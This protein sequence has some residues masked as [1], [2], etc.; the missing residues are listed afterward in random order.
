MSFINLMEVIYPIGSIHFSVDA[1]S[2]ASI[3]GG[4][5]SSIADRFLLGA[6]T[7]YKVNSTGG[8]SAHTLT[9]NEIPSHSHTGTNGTN[10]NIEVSKGGNTGSYGTTAGI[11]LEFNSNPYNGGGRLT[12]TCRH[13]SQYIYGEEQ[14]KVGEHLWQ[15]LISQI[16][17]EINS[18]GLEPTIFHQPL[19]AQLRYGVEV[20]HRLP[21]ADLLSQQEQVMQL[22]QQEELLQS[23][24][25]MIKSQDHYGQQQQEIVLEKL[26][27]YLAKE[28]TMGLMQS[29]EQLAT[30]MKTDLLILQHIFGEELAN[31]SFLGGVL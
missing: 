17:L 3:I 24:L 6:G 9:I 15:Q 8:E 31:T 26:K 4:T 12:T 13:T 16:G 25:D 11:N 18:I 2:P 14:P 20:G 22:E 1:A 23:L 5:W 27:L 28:Q 19:L 30:L 21:Q 7:T 10:W 29:Q